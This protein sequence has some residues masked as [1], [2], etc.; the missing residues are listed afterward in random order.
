MARGRRTWMWFTHHRNSKGTIACQDPSQEFWILDLIGFL[1]KTCTLVDSCKRCCLHCDGEVCGHLLYIS[2]SARFANFLGWFGL[3]EI[4][5][6]G[7]DCFVW[8][9]LVWLRLFCLVRIVL[10]GLIWIDWDSFAWFGFIWAA[11]PFQ[12]GWLLCMCRSPGPSMIRSRW[13]AGEEEEENDF[14]YMVYL[15]F[16]NLHKN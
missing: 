2:L 1:V 16:A 5:L 13:S 11:S 7:R 10:L 3:V 12:L 15:H 6:L 4:V 8:S 9:D 14:E